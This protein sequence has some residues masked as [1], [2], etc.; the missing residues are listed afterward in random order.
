MR[1]MLIILTLLFF[2]VSCS[3][4]PKVVPLK[5]KFINKND[6]LGLILK[7]KNNMDTMCLLLQG[8]LRDWSSISNYLTS[9]NSRA[10][11]EVLYNF[12]YS[13]RNNYIVLSKKNFTQSEQQEMLLAIYNE[14]LK[15]ITLPNDTIHYYY[16]KQGMERLYT[17]QWKHQKGNWCLLSDTFAVRVP[18]AF[19]LSFYGSTDSLICFGNGCGQECKYN[20]FLFKHQPCVYKQY[21]EVIL[22]SLSKHLVVYKRNIYNGEILVENLL[23]GKQQ[24]IQLKNCHNKANCVKSVV[25]NNNI[26]SIKLKTN[27]G[28]IVEKVKVFV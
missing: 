10:S 1:L 11:Q 14:P 19:M 21:Y 27:A 18:T 5:V 26:L 6:T 7:H 25:L 20:L 23:T 4:E 15:N 28:Y 13:Y 16:L 3:K 2:F 17:L 8:N 9:D 12:I 24:S 22:V